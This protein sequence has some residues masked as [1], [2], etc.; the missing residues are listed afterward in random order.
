[1]RYMD[2]D[3]IGATSLPLEALQNFIDFT[4]NFPA[5]QFTHNITEQSL[6]FLD[7]LLTIKNDTIATSIYY[8]DTDAGSFLD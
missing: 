6:P 1:M 5:L 8:T 2:D 3:T 7:I 4:N